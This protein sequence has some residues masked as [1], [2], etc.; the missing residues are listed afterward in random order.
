M[1]TTGKKLLKIQ[2]Y[3]QVQ[4]NKWPIKKWAKELNRHVSKDIQMANKHMKRCSTS[5]VIR[6]MQ[7][8]ATMRY[9][10]KPVK[11]WE[12]DLN[13]H[14]SKEDIQKANKHMKRCSILLIIREVQIKAT[15]RYHFN[16]FLYRAIQSVTEWLCSD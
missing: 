6:E 1:S 3:A 9:H 14:F 4:K 5:L 15:M 12:K 13:W 2:T 7:I 8:K 10:F 11:K 16:H